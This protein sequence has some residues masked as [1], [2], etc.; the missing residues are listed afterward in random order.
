M[1]SPRVVTA[2]IVVDVV[3]ILA[4]AT[5]GRIT[6]GE[7]ATPGGVLETAWP[8]LLG[9]GAG[10]VTV[11]RALDSAEVTK[12]FPAGVAV[13]AWTM[14]GG[15]I[16]RLLTATGIAWP[17]VLTAAIITAGLLLGWRLIARIFL[18]LRPGRAP[19]PAA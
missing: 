1:H 15:V 17:F 12:V 4:F 19:R 10:W 11:L 13:W 14:L 5:A 3:A 9:L 8:F 7:V 6:H 16:L 18:R 2:A